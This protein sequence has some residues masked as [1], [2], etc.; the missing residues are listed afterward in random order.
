MYTS[1]CVWIQLI[2]MIRFEKLNSK[3]SI[4][5]PVYPNYHIP[6]GTDKTNLNILINTRSNLNV[7]E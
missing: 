1:D 5:N 6:L 3:L 7:L 4:K 2:K